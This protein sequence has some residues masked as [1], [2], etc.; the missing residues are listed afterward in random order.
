MTSKE[1]VRRAIEF[2]NPDRVPIYCFNGAVESGD[3]VCFDIK[4]SR[5]FS[6]KD[7]S[8]DEWGFQWQKLDDTMGQPLDFVIK[9]Y[10]QLDDYTPP[11]ANANGRF[12]GIDEFIKRYKDKFIMIG[13]AI[14]GFTT[15]TF[16]RGFENTLIDL[17]E[18]RENLEKIIGMVFGY[19]NG[20]IEA[21]C[22]YKEI[23]AFSFHDDWGSQNSAF[24]GRALFREV[25]LPRYKVQFDKL[26]KAGKKVFF[27]SC[28]YVID[29]I[30]DL[31]AA[32]VDMFNFNQPSVMGV[33]RLADGFGGKT[34]F[35]CPVDLQTIALT[36]GKK[37]IYDYTQ[38]M[39]E[40]FGSFGGGFIGYIEEYKSIG[41]SDEN[42]NLCRQ[43]LLD[44]GKY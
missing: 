2:K 1:R 19:E 33:D 31:I 28:G 35:V 26:H 17:Y 40:R 37:E 44:L 29:L 22:N 14:T 42:Y 6:A 24:I 10:M 7:K 32:G 23:D 15:V 41:L 12:D 20:L 11:D 38:K 27:H 4:R 3:V 5:N 9:D 18:D 30:P 16:I 21:A 8:F 36:G 39:I 43:A 25:F 13:P 34:A